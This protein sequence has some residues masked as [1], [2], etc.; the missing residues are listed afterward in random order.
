VSGYPSVSETNSATH[1]R[2]Y[3]PTYRRPDLLP[4]A[5]KSLLTQTF[6][7]WQCEVHNDDPADSFPARLIET[8]G[9]RRIQ[10]RQHQRNIGANATFNLIYRP[11][12]ED[13]YTLLEDDNWWEP[14]FLETM[15]GELRRRPDVVMA[16]CNQKI[17]EELSDGTWRDTGRLVSAVHGAVPQLMEFGRFRQMVGALHS[18]GA[19]LI[20]SRPAESYE[21][22]L[23]WPF[24]LVEPFRERM[25]RHPLLF[26]PTPLAA[27]CMTRS[28][29]RAESRADWLTAQTV[30]AATFL[31]HCRYGAVEF[32]A[33]FVAARRM[34]PPLTTA[35][36]LAALMERQ[37]RR[38][39]RHS[40][41]IDWLVLFR[42]LVRRPR[43]F[44]AVLQSQRR[45]SAWWSLLDQYS[46]ARFEELGSHSGAV[47]FV[48]DPEPC[49]LHQRQR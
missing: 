5:L 17:W 37:N 1:V 24:A 15:I 20:R 48:P 31:K 6:T 7:G 21:V 3:L 14:A 9:D 19:M 4:R 28:T 43:V 12:A 40:R 45:R 18:N 44:W 16:W 22:P 39:L 2:V 11:V 49:D 30:L 35:M 42:G 46:A 41:P 25:M 36:I 32:A 29:A 47:P 26:V 33:F 34:R 8:I 10:L 13:F 27:Y 38:L 23:G